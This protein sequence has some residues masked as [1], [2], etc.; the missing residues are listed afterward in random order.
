MPRLD[1][2]ERLVFEPIV[3]PPRLVVDELRIFYT[4][5]PALA[6]F[7]LVVA[8]GASQLTSQVGSLAAAG[9]CQISPLRS[10]RGFR[11]FGKLTVWTLA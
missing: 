9:F 8:T 11:L 3:Y 2:G 4:D 7:A 5:R 1:K 6:V 10:V